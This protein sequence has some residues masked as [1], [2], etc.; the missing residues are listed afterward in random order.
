MLIDGIEPLIDR[1]ESL[2][3]GVEPLID[4]VEPPVDDVEPL[5]HPRD[6]LAH[7]GLRLDDLADALFK[8]R[9]PP[10]SWDYENTSTLPSSK[11]TGQ[12]EFA[13][14]L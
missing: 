3:G 8:E 7:A 12:L 2:I 9:E 11:T 4:D 5:I 1:V 10:F 6:E 14:G 13:R